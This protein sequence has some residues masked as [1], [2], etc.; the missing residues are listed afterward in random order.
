MKKFPLLF[1]ILVSNFVYAQK[2]ATLFEQLA[3]VNS[4]WNNQVDFDNNLKNLPAKPFSEQQLIQFHLQET[5]KLLR[6]RNLSNLSASLQKQR[7]KILDILNSYWKRGLFPINDM[8]KNR[9]PYFIDKQNTYCAVGYLMQQTGADDIAKE[10]K[11]SQNYSFLKDISHSK[12]LNWVT[13]SGLNINE[14]AMIQPTYG[15]GVYNPPVLLE[16]HYNNTGVDV[17]EYIEIKQG[18]YSAFNTVYFYDQNNVLYKT[19][20]LS[21]MQYANGVYYYTFP[22]NE[23]FADV[24]KIEIANAGVY[25]FFN[26]PLVYSNLISTINYNATSVQVNTTW[27]YPGTPILASFNKGES[28]TTPV[29][30]TLSFCGTYPTGASL[31]SWN[32]VSQA[33]TPGEVS[34]CVYFPALVPITLS[35]FDYILKSNKVVLQWQTE[36]ETNSSHFEIERSADGIKF[37][38]IKNIT[39]SGVSNTAKQYEYVDENPLYIN[40]YRLKQ[41]DLNGSS[42][43]SKIL[44]VKVAEASPI[45]ILENPIANNLNLRINLNASSV[46]LISIYDMM[47]R[48]VKSFSGLT[49][50]Q[51]LDIA[52][53]IGGNYLLQLIDVNGQTYN[54]QFLKAQ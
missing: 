9:Q 1:A 48:K 27:I 26:P 46:K 23:N 4:E 24:G 22:A 32:L 49:S 45:K 17:N 42:T 31:S 14:L 5:E 30:N 51:N 13:N 34:S 28:E 53:L 52:K 21:A 11:Q 54:L 20:L 50:Y 8:H 37:E 43:Y 39:A 6:S 47:G 12:L 3:S 10:I 19:L 25:T 7:I 35:K 33:A 44:F 29:G 36:N 41:V 38:K 40:H 16:M 15:G 2:E 18:Y